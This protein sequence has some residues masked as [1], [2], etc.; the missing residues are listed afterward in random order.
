MSQDRGD[1]VSRMS[2]DLVEMKGSMARVEP[3]LEDVTR[4]VHPLRRINAR[5]RRRER[6]SGS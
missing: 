1:E 4:V 5:D 3:Q 6:E 2:E